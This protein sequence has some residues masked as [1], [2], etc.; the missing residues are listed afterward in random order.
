MT[1]FFSKVLSVKGRNL[2]I[3]IG[4]RPLEAYTL[5]S[6]L[7]FVLQLKNDSVRAE[8]SR[9]NLGH[10]VAVPDLKQYLKDELLI[11][12]QSGKVNFAVSDSWLKLLKRHFSDDVLTMV[13]KDLRDA[14]LKAQ[15][16]NHQQDEVEV[17][18][19]EEEV[20]PSTQ[21]EDARL[22]DGE[23]LAQ[24]VVAA[25]VQPTEESLQY[26]I[27]KPLLPISHTIDAIKSELSDSSSSSD[28]FDGIVDDE[29]PDDVPNWIV[30]ATLIPSQFARADYCK[31]YSLKDY[32]IN[33]LL[34]KELKK[35]R[36][37][38][39]R[40]E[41][42]ERTRRLE[43]AVNDTTHSKREE[44]I[45]C[46][47]GFVAKYE[48]IP[49]NRSL[50]LAL[51]LNHKL[52]HSYLQ[53]MQ[54]VR[55]C[56]PGTLGE[57]LTAAIYVCKWL[58]RK[59][60]KKS[61]RVPSIIRRYMDWRNEYQASAARDRMLNDKDELQE[62][63]KWLEWTQFTAAVAQLRKEWDF[64]SQQ[65][66]QPTSQ[67]ARQLHDLL[68]LGIYAC[69]PS[70]GSEVRL[71]EYIAED[72]VIQL[73]GD[74]TFKEFVMEQQINILTQKQGIWTMIVSRFKNVASN[75]VDSTDLSNFPWWTELL[76]LYLHG[77][78]W[79]LMKRHCTHNY[80]FMTGQGVRFETGYF[81]DYIA[82]RIEKLTGVHVATNAIR[83]SFVTHFYNSD[84][85]RDQVLCESIA[86]VMRH[87]TSE[88]R[89]TYDRRSSSERK[90]KGLE[91]LRN[92]QNVHGKR[93]S[94][95]RDDETPKDFSK[96]PRMK[97][98]DD[99]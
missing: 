24:I 14:F 62:K 82:R 16:G 30:K 74:R 77:G 59:K 3:F 56:Q 84:A 93:D 13:K 79:D 99:Q 68:L 32:D 64:A 49:N 89:R 53:Y 87:T 38:W 42:H 52:F 9:H 11:P 15:E 72:H 8:L 19:M 31:S 41:N 22:C 80:I 33:K 44:R 60:D 1:T 37:W 5:V 81:S 69:I 90:N 94:L 39:T 98:G 51:A 75:G 78:Y 10:L 58:F 27:I 91:F 83:S 95:L 48:C 17:K 71:L 73:K 85:S 67:S 18:V 26:T 70:R 35:L 34:K 40:K 57:A 6:D 36:K 63:N 46:F 28:S 20:P 97:N 23:E 96:R 12:H 50:T 7:A 54:Q 55:E 29:L 2:R 76:Q 65:H 43:K 66:R 61:N 88:A 4:T 92:E 86:S 47:L 45:K 21:H 25:K